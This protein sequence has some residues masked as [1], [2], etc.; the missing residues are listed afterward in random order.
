[1]PRFELY[2]RVMNTLFSVFRTR[3]VAVLQKSRTDFENLKASEYFR[4]HPCPSLCVLGIPQS[5]L[6]TNHFPM[7][8]HHLHRRTQPPHPSRS[9]QISVS[10]RREEQRK[11][12]HWRC[13]GP[14]PTS[15]LPWFYNLEDRIRDCGRRLGIWLV[16]FVH[17]CLYS[18]R[19]LCSRSRGLHGSSVWEGVEEGD[20]GGEMEDD[21]WHLVK[22]CILSFRSSYA[23]L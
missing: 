21:S 22:A 15:Q 12:V 13:L 1:M 20:G 2:D 14:G 10:K 11:S 7:D 23:Y 17:V 9:Q 5:Y 19:H 18:V 3:P 8:A 6:V 4:Q 16:G